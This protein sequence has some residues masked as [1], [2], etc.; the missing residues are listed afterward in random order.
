MHPETDLLEDIADS[1][2]QPDDAPCQRR[3]PLSVEEVRRKHADKREVLLAAESH[4]GQGCFHTHGEVLVVWTLH[5]G[6]L[7]C[8]LEQ[9]A[10]QLVLVSTTSGYIALYSE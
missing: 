3:R 4:N 6:D 5:A 1:V 2:V 9:V 8:M 7:L 10:R